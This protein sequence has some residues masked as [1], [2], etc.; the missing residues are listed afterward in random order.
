MNG[1]PITKKAN[2]RL[3]PRSC[4]PSVCCDGTA[5]N[6]LSR[7]SVDRVFRDVIDRCAIQQNPGGATPRVGS[8]DW[9]DLLA[10]QSHMGKWL[11]DL[12]RPLRGIVELGAFRRTS[13]ESGELANNPS[14]E[15]RSDTLGAQMDTEG[16]AQTRCSQSTQ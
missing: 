11:R 1:R 13:K 2:G 4:D 9:H 14:L 8:S 10:K 12:H 5:Q 6:V 7:E 16:L 3:Q 15:N